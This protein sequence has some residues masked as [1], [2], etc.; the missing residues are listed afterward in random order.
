MRVG[1]AGALRE[2]VALNAGSAAAVGSSDME[3]YDMRLPLDDG[4]TVKGPI[5]MD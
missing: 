3:S 2:S 4:C 1:R 5:R